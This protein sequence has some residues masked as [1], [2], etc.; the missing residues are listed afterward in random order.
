[1]KITIT[2]REGKKD[3]E[4][5]QVTLTP[6]DLIAKLWSEPE[7]KRTKKLL[8]P[9]DN[10]NA[11]MTEEQ[12]KAFL[13]KET[14]KLKDGNFTLKMEK[15][16]HDKTS[17]N[18]GLTLKGKKSAF[19]AI[20]EEILIDERKYLKYRNEPKGKQ[21]LIPHLITDRFRVLSQREIVKK[22]TR[23]KEQEPDLRKE[24]DEKRRN[25]QNNPVPKAPS[26]LKS[27]VASP[28][29]HG[30]AVAILTGLVLHLTGFSLALTLG[31]ALGVGTLVGGIESFTKWRK[32][33]F[34]TAYEQLKTTQEKDL[35]KLPEPEKNAFKAGLEA[36]S[37]ASWGKGLF[38]S[39]QH[40]DKY[41]AGLVSNGPND[42]VAK[43]ILKPK[44]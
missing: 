6:E 25:A 36:K 12:A 18:L 34:Q 14:A 29:T 9:A 15:V 44:A 21:T 28:I 32:N 23:M 11:K 20:W 22:T 42:P 4:Y 16:E 31:L 7:S 1:M 30:I 37:W 24:E 2:N 8:K 38:H 19:G 13:N 33:K 17:R 5:H 41:G 10:A 39:W 27:L 3:Q 35:D 43:T 40:Y 26:F